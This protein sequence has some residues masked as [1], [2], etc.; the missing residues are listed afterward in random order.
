ME[1]L[2]DL[3]KYK[4]L[5]FQNI[6]KE[7]TN[8]FESEE[9]ETISSTEV[10]RFLHSLKGTAGTL[11]LEGLAQLARNLLAELDEN[12]EYNW[13]KKDLKDYLFQLIELTYEYEHFEEEQT[14]NNREWH[15]DTQLVQ[16]VDD[17]ISML[18]LLKDVLEEKGLMV[19]TNV[20]PEKAVEQY[21]E[22]QPDCLIIDI[23]LPTKNGFEILNEIQQH[24]EKYFIPNIMISIDH[25]K[26]TRIK[27]FQ[28]GAD[29]FISK[30]IEI[31]EF[32]VR[33]ERHLQRKKIFDQS[34]LIDELT[35]VYNRRFLEDSY[36]KQ[37]HDLNRT[38]QVFTICI[39]DLD[40]FK[41]INDTYGH[42]TGDQVLSEFA[43]FL[44]NEVRKGDMVYRVG[45]EEFSIIFPR[46][47]DLEV[48]KCVTNMIT[49]FSEKVFT[50]DEKKF[51]I[52]FSAGV[53]TVSNS[54]TSLKDA[55]READ[56]ALYEA[57]R[58]GRA[59]VE[60][61][62]NSVDLYNKK[63]LHI[64]VVDDDI[65]IRS[66][67]EKL[68]RGIQDER[69]DIKIGIYEDGATFLQSEYAQN[70]ENHFLILDGMMPGMDGLEV[71]QAIK[72]GKYADRFTVLM[73]TGR[74]RDEDIASALKLGADDYVTKPFSTTELDARIKRLL[75][76]VK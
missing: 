32:L 59:R 75:K 2:V 1:L 8:W 54:D 35:Q 12:S 6:K 55:L 10:Y 37:L 64:S 67:L 72:G 3:Q 20:D 68:L 11:N 57:K 50:H 31:D 42:L 73:L 17:D 28:N 69:L 76:R 48:Q 58:L 7:L 29:D 71:L 16:I 4:N 56:V 26:E 51:S 40:Y 60:L 36:T 44:K 65:I 41:K 38:G 53:Y 46:A 62:H 63:V 18:I 27:A 19:I 33:I 24:N 47:N 39:L 23:H 43:Q 5:L 45:G 49:R 34:V 21:Y 13:L 74:K 14:V 25:D 70:G 52:T 61:S 15:H 66:I 9:V 22:L 30:P